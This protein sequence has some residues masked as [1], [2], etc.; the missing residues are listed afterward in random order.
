MGGLEGYIGAAALQARNGPDAASKIQPADSAFRAIV[1]TIRICHALYRPHHIY[2][3]GGTGIR[4]GPL[5]APLRS[6][7]EIGLTSLARSGWTFDCGDSDFHAACGAA[8]AA[9]SN[10]WPG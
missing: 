4:L 1:R 8:R 9:Q 2:L 10:T 3:A 6:A 7:I 5:L